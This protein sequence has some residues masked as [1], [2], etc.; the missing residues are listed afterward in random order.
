MNRDD[1]PPLPASARG[2]QIA[3]IFA[4]VAERLTAYYEH[5]QWLTEAQGASLAGDWLNRTKRSLSNPP[6]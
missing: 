3:L 4:L 2:T 5:G 1:A 6:L